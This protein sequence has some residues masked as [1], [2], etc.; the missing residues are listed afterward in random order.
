MMTRGDEISSPPIKVN[1]PLL[2]RALNARRLRE[3]NN[4]IDYVSH[5]GLYVRMLKEGDLSI[6]EFRS[7]RGREGSWYG[8]RRVYGL[9]CENAERGEFFES[10]IDK[11]RSEI[12]IGNLIIIRKC[13]LIYDKYENWSLVRNF[14]Q[15]CNGNSKLCCAKWSRFHCK[16]NRNFFP[17]PIIS[18]FKSILSIIL[19][20]VSQVIIKIGLRGEWRVLRNRDSI[21]IISNYETELYESSG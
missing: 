19:S 15:G 2:T 9:F 1:R 20:H 21:S 4:I 8:K 5:G 18:R 13:V 12:S 6:A 7:L 10:S 11:C 16:R 14:K 3:S 17:P